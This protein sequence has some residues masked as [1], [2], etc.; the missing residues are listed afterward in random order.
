MS[1]LRC[2]LV[3]LSMLALAEARCFCP[4][5]CQNPP[6][7]PKYSSWWQPRSYCNDVEAQAECTLANVEITD[8]IDSMGR[9]ADLYI[10]T[11]AQRSATARPIEFAL[12]RSKLSE[13]MEANKPI[14]DCNFGLATATLLAGVD[15]VCFS[16]ELFQ[17]C[18]HVALAA[19]PYY[20][21]IHNALRQG[22]RIDED[23]V[24]LGLVDLNGT[25]S[26]L[27]AEFVDVV[28]M[29]GSIKR[30]DIK[31]RCRSYEALVEIVGSAASRLS[32]HFLLTTAVVLGVL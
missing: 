7:N 32:W 22:I 13:A 29:R 8:M 19:E 1:S 3:L 17:Q 27:A 4:K 15:D 9:N 21:N 5:Y 26:P 31:I 12:L 6:C 16:P 2:L 14:G 18:A 11:M 23:A 10:Y 20:L 25:L 28:R 30:T 24:R